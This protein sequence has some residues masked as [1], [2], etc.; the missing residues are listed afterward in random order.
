MCGQFEHAYKSA[1][2]DDES[3]KHTIV[4]KIKAAFRSIEILGKKEKNYIYI[5]YIHTYTHNKQVSRG[6]HSK[7]VFWG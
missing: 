6:E 3:H 7:Q 4:F 5:Q 2:D 1:K